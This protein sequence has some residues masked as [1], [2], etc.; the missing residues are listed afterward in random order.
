MFGAQ[1][2]FD[3]WRMDPFVLLGALL[4]HLH[5]SGCVLLLSYFP[6]VTAPSDLKG[7]INIVLQK[8]C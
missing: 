5:S 1:Q 3:E 4:T 6:L 8:K 2:T 7:I